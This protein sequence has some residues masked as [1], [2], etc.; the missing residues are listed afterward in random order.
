MPKAFVIPSVVYFYGLAGA[1]KN[2][3]GDIFG[4]LT[5]WDVYHAD[6]D[7]TPDML[8]A[9]EEG[10]VFTEQMRDRFYAIVADHIKEI[11]KKNDHIVVTQATYKQRHRDCL[12]SGIAG[13]DMVCVTA[14]DARIIDRLQKRGDFITPDYAA[15]MRRDFDPPAAG[16]KTIENNA[17]ESEIVAQLMRIYPGCC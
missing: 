12:M 8:Q 13:M 3:V 17:G 4:S 11:R 15:R 2:Y 6:V 10:R 9:I 16:A 14:D 5:G 1:G 7:L